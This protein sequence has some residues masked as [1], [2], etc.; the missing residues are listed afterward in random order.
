VT[1]M[2]NAESTVNAQYPNDSASASPIRQA[3]DNCLA[4]GTRLADFE[5]TGIVGEGGFGIVYLA[6]DHSLRRTVA[7]KEYMP[8]ALAG[9]GR[10][11][12]VVVRSGRHQETFDTGLK[13]FINEARL[14]ARFDHPALVKVYRFWEENKTGYMAM[15]YYEG[16]TLKEVVRDQ[17]ELIN[18]AW[19][20]AMLKPMLEALETLY[21]IQILHRDISPDNIMIQKNGDAVLLDFGAARQII[22]DMTHALTVILKPGYAPVEQYAD[23][24]SMTQGPWTDI[25]A[26]SAVVYFAI[27]KK[28]PPTSVGRMIKDPIEMLIGEANSGYSLA[29]L[30]AIDKGLAVKPQDR[31]Q[32][33]AEFRALLDFET[34]TSSL[35]MESL[36]ALV[37][38]LP[39]AQRVAER[40]GKTK[41]RARAVRP[42]PNPDGTTMP[43]ARV[44][45][46]ARRSWILI[47]SGLVVITLYSGYHLFN[48][49]PARIP[50][51]KLAPLAE[52]A[53]TATIARTPGGGADSTAPAAVPDKLAAPAQVSVSSA[54]PT[55]P[56]T[57]DPTSTGAGQSTGAVRIMIKPWG[58][59]VVDGKA[60]GVSP[61]LKHLR[62]PEGRHQ[63]TI[64]NPNFAD[65][66]FEITVSKKKIG[67][68]AH[69]FSSTSKGN[70]TR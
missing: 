10:D 2:K 22:G 62:L 65:Y 18:E 46:S 48:G 26:L 60:K 57:V 44:R 12:S 58:S 64:I 33:I 6:F 23:D 19:L 43:L 49:A 32:S 15:R 25:Y 30:A 36:P 66:S 50:G 61:P 14:L 55:S 68:I 63:V 38:P 28:A 67:N 29:F 52:I 39:I 3:S 53:P 59:I 8:G 47:I 34:P 5:I 13:S 35:H 45:A 41:Q 51:A 37:A 24:I 1:D 11:Q 40:N 70:T 17:P 42:D 54:A 21:R 27:L 7:I 4:V 9:R 69:D 16:E 20:K 56:P 31:P